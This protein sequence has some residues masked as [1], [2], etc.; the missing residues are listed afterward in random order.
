MGWSWRKALNFGPLRLNL[1]KKGVG[2]SVGIRGF[3][4]GQDVA[5]RRYRQTS[6]PNTGL[7]KRTYTGRTARLRNWTG[8][9]LIAIFILLLCIKMLLK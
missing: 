9:A 7:Y 6:I 2:Y 1:S 3:R 8:P 5:G 4:V